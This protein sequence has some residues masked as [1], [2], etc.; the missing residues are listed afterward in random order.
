M[1]LPVR[2]AV[3]ITICMMCKPIHLLQKMVN[4]IHTPITYLL[5]NRCQSNQ[6]KYEIL[7]KYEILLILFLSYHIE[8][9]IKSLTKE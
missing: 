4:Y 2:F 9:F 7:S 8:T 3:I 5:F 6:L 1:I